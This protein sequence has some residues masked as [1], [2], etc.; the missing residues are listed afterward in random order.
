MIPL[1]ALQRDAAGEYVFVYQ[2]DGTVRRA[3][4]VSGQ[5]VVDRIEI[6]SGLEV[7][8]KVVTRG[9]LALAPGRPVQPVSPT[10]AR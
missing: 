8:D 2:A 3:D 7:G 6:R 5:R 1:V 10:D 4:V 9:F